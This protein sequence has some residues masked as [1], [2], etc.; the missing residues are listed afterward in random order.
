MRRLVF[1]AATLL[2]ASPALA[3]KNG[4]EVAH[5]WSRPAAAGRVGVAYLT[6]TDTGAPDRLTGA[7]SPVA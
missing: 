7:S 3:Q 5:A 2:A 6:I 4:L 1:V